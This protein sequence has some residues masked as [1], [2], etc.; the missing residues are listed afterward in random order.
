MTKTHKLIVIFVLNI[1]LIIK[2]YQGDYGLFSSLIWIISIIFLYKI[3]SPPD[4]LKKD[5]RLPIS[6]ILLLFFVF[7]IKVIFI[8]LYPSSISFHG[9]EA[10]NSRNAQISFEIGVNTGVWNLLS[11]GQGTLNKM[12]ALWYFLQGG[13]IYLLG[14]SLLSVKIF[15]IISD[16]ILCCFIYLIIKKLFDKRLALFATILYLSL[17]IAI[18]FSMTGYQNLQSTV[19]LFAS[20]Y[21][22]CLIINT[23][24][25]QELNYYCLTSGII[26]GVS[27]YFY[28]SSVINPVICLMII[29]SIFIFE[30]RNNFYKKL[31][32]FLNSLIY[33]FTGFIIPAIPFLYYSFYKYDFANGRSS[34]YVFT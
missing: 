1:W 27:L 33:F 25:K 34:E 13:L 26:C 29:F 23:S 9:D 11:S 24:K 7:F 19:M 31:K 16:L 2:L 20:I 15:T 3:V 28:L 10:I 32:Y 18:H 12:P 4:Y 22:L 17:P 30:D 8:S 6:L 14:P 5:F 21:F